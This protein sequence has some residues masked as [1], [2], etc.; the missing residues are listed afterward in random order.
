MEAHR[1]ALATRSWK[2]GVEELAQVPAP[3]SQP[4][5]RS[6]SVAAKLHMDPPW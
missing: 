6:Q 5:Q 2:G 3:A 1:V 4:E